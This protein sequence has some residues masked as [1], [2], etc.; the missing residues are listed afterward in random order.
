[1]V[2]GSCRICCYSRGFVYGSY[3]T[4][5]KHKIFEVFYLFVASK[6]QH[7]QI[8][9]CVILGKVILKVVFTSFYISIWGSVDCIEN[10]IFTNFYAKRFHCF[11]IYAQILPPFERERIVYKYTYPF[12]PVILSY[13]MQ[14]ILTR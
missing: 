10:Y 3:H 7:I 2:D 11:R 4:I 12:A 13:L 14:T 8:K 5:T 1:M 6:I 9:D